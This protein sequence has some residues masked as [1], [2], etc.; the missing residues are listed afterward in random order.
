LGLVTNTIYN[1]QIP[2]DSTPGLASEEVDQAI[3]SC[4][5]V[6]ENNAST[7]FG[8]EKNVFNELKKHADAINKRLNKL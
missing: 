2:K 7:L 5:K 6:L 8:G 3:R 4:S 1:R